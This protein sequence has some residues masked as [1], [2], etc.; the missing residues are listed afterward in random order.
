MDIQT[1]IVKLLDVLQQQ[2]DPI[3]RQQLAGLLT[4]AVGE[5]DN[6][7]LVMTEKAVHEGLVKTKPAKSKT[8]VI[9]PTGKKFRKTPNAIEV[10]TEET[11][12]DDELS[13]KLSIVLSQRRG[14]GEL[15]RVSSEHTRLQIKLIRAIDR[16]IALDEFAEQEHL[17]FDTVLDEL[18][19]MLQSGH[20][21]NIRYFVDEVI[22]EQDTQEILD[23]FDAN[24]DN[25]KLCTDEWGDVYKTQELRLIHYLWETR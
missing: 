9:T 11:A 25:M 5:D 19:K 12:N 3:T 1:H 17:D 16:K 23:F 13:M 7:W 18:E 2:E 20:R 4:S 15:A 6:F 8:V 22:E 14:S 24:G 21:F 10:H